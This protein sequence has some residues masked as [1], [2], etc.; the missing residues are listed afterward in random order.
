MTGCTVRTVVMLMNKPVMFLSI[1]V[2]AFYMDIYVYIH[3]PCSCS[4]YERCQSGIHVHCYVRTC[5]YVMYRYTYTATLHAHVHVHVQCTAT[6]TATYT[7]T[8]TYRELANVA[9]WVVDLWCLLLCPCL[10]SVQMRLWFITTRCHA[11]HI[12]VLPSPNVVS[13]SLPYRL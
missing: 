13:S 9:V 2:S 10:A 7:C 1:L 11:C 5:S 4:V 6:S 12:V 8:C 3:A